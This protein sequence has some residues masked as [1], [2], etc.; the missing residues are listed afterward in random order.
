MASMQEQTA[1][2][3]LLSAL[4]NNDVVTV[5]MTSTAPCVSGS[6]AT[7]NAITM[8]VNPSVPASVSI[9]AA[10]SG[11]VCAGTSVTFTATPV[12][13]G[14]PSYQWKVNGVNAGTNSPEFTSSTLANNDIVTV[15]MTSGIT[16]TTGSPATSN[17]VTM[18]VNSLPVATL[19]SSEPD[20]TIC[21]GTSVTFTA[22]G[23]DN[24][25]F[26]IGGVSRQNGT[27]P[28]FIT[29]TLTNGQAVTVVVT[30]AE[31]VQ[32]CSSYRPCIFCQSCAVYFH[33]FSHYLFC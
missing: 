33:V 9:A 4:A 18:T 27:S 19:T 29:N 25:N 1:Q 21:A 24:Y 14:T 31:P 16:C 3:S 8:N 32:C 22:G 17:A 23:G 20:N 5:V 10:P 26:I 7:S 12:N 6:P 28:T 15:V 13:G 2:T 11:A 30:N